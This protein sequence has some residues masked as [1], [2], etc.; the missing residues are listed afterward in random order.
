VPATASRATRWAS[1]GRPCHRRVCVGARRWRHVV[2]GA[3]S[4]P[5]AG[6]R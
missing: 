1:L 2:G 6:R 4:A 5:L 3:G